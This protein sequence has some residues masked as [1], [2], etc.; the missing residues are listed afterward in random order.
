MWIA[1]IPLILALILWGGLSWLGMV[2]AAA[3][4]TP[5][6]DIPGDA[7]VTY[8]LAIPLGMTVVAALLLAASWKV[9]STD[10]VGCA[11]VLHALLLLPYL[12]YY[13]GGM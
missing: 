5:M 8:Y 4:G 11:G 6:A 10:A 12:F 9:R 13:T 2:S 7:Q 1:R 3:R